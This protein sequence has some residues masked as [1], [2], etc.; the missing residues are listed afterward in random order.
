MEA[1]TY[2]ITET[3][4][5]DSTYNDIAPFTVTISNDQ[6]KDPDDADSAATGPD[7]TS[8]HW[9][10]V[11]DSVEVTAVEEGAFTFNVINS[12]GTTLPSTGGI[13]TTIFYVVGGTLVAGAVVMLITKKRMSIN[14]Q[15]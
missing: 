10:V 11:K 7:I 9:K 15:K 2:T 1:G 12:K 13:G 8:A 6:L 5:P 14:D 3:Q 4:K